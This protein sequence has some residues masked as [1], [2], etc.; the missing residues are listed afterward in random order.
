[1]QGLTLEGVI[2]DRLCQNI[3]LLDSEIIF[4]S[5]GSLSGQEMASAT[6][7]SAELLIGQ[8]H[9][10]RRK[11]V[12]LVSLVLDTFRRGERLTGEVTMVT[13]TFHK[14]LRVII[15][16]NFANEIFTLVIA[17][18]ELNPKVLAFQVTELIDRFNSEK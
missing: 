4:S 16:P 2:G 10:L 3:L 1:M 11:Y 17:T 14:N 12:S 8:D 7:P 6:K 9:S 5:I 13:A 18:K 15:L